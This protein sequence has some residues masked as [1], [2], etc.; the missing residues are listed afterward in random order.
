M[1]LDLQGFLQEVTRHKFELH[2]LVVRQHG[3]QVAAFNWRDMQRNNIHS[4]SKSITTMAVGMAIE[5]GIMRLDEHPAEIFADRLP[6]NPPQN[7]LDITIRD[8][9]LMT[10]GHTVSVLPGGFGSPENPGRDA[11]ED[12]VDWIKYMFSLDVPNPPGTNWEYGNFG[13]YICSVIIQDRTGQ[14]LRDYLKP[15]LFHPLKINNP[16]WFQSPAGYSIGCGGLHLTAEELS[17]VAQVLVDEGK[18]EGKQLVSAEW[19]RE[20]TANHVS[21]LTET[22]KR[23][24]DRSAG[25]GYMFWRCARDNAYRAVGWGGQYAIILP[26]QDACIVITSFDFHEQKLLNCVWRHIVP[27]LKENA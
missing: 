12:D 5:E 23:D 6:A 3:E 7:L 1:K 17:R 24:P 26:E 25:Y 21:N 22:S 20:A 27:Q 2:N 13:S 19:V 11:L 10:T 8:A 18:W 15:R 4:A 16:Q 14:T 9:L